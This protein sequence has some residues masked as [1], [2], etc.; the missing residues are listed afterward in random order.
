MSI[1]ALLQTLLEY[2]YAVRMPEIS[3]GGVG[4]KWWD[5][6]IKLFGFLPEEQPTLGGVQAG[7]HADEGLEI[8]HSHF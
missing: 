4:R 1:L 3:S 8:V 6:Y 7:L 5:T 2:C